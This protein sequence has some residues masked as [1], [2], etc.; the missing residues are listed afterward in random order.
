MGLGAILPISC[1]ER[2]KLFSILVGFL[3]LT[4]EIDLPKAVGDRALF[5]LCTVGTFVYKGPHSEY[6]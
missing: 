3:F 6:F 1:F 4:D 2:Y 5:V